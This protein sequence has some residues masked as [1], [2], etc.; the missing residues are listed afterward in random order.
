MLSQ[1]QHFSRATLSCH[2]LFGRFFARVKQLSD[3]HFLL[4]FT[5]IPQGLIHPSGNYPLVPLH[6]L[7]LFSQEGRETPVFWSANT[8]GV[9]VFTTQVVALHHQR[10]HWPPFCFCHEE[11]ERH[12]RHGHMVVNIWKHNV[13]SHTNFKK[14]IKTKLCFSCVEGLVYF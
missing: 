10:L 9:F 1:K 5:A 14:W 13:I 6:H 4:D 12:Q 8:W 7:P 11:Q 3:F 2:K